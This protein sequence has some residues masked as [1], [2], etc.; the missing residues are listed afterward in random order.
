MTTLLS[1]CSKEKQCS[2]I[3]ILWSYEVSGAR[4]LSVQYWNG[5]LLQRSVYKWIL[6][7]KNGCISV[8]QKEGMATHV[9]NIKRAHDMILLDKSRTIDKVANCLQILVT[10]LPT[11]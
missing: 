7:L 8:I 6:K 11:K 10:V 4:H 3:W 9:G 2:A 1:V 5:V